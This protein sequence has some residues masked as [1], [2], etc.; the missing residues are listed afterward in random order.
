MQNNTI[1]KQNRVY[2]P[3]IIGLSLFAITFLLYPLYV[4]YVDTN[5]QVVALEKSKA[6]KQKKID[7]IVAMQQLFS[8]TGMT[9]VKSKVQKYNHPFDTSNL[10]EAVMVNK[11][12]K[13]SALSPAQISIGGITVDKWRKLPS[14]L[15]LGT[16]SVSV[17]A[18]T[19]DQIIDYITYLATESSYAFTIDS[20]VLPLDTAIAA[21]DNKWL[22]LS[23][24]LG[25]YYYE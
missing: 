24:S 12:T 5:T 15:S 10:M 9:E 16:V 1:H 2:A 11:F 6:E 21:Q 22:T 3:I 7:E 13:A 17:S 25:V 23:L 20:I 19:P 14:G 8:W 18:E 4:E